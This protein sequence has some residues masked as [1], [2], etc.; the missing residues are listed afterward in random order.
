MEFAER[1]FEM[2]AEQKNFDRDNGQCGASGMKSSLV[3][4]YPPRRQTIWNRIVY[5]PE[6][7]QSDN[8]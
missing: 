7:V 3:F 5:P 2:M 4:L 8:A 6:N 1:F